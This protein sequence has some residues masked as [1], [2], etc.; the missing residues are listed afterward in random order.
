MSLKV[1]AQIIDGVVVNAS[2]YDEDTSQEW[3]ALV[4][5]DFD[6]VRIVDEAGIGWTVEEDGLRPPSPYPSWVW[7]GVEWEAPVPMPEGPHYWNESAG[8]WVPVA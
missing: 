2:V 5:P 8:G 3:L 1:A 4:E 6:E 7:N